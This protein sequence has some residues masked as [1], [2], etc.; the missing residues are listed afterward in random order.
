MTN[1]ITDIMPRSA[2][3]A[4]VLRSAV[5]RILVCFGILGPLSSVYGW[6]QVRDF[7]AQ[8][9]VLDNNATG[10]ITLQ[11]PTTITNNYSITLP[12]DTLGAHSGLL[13]FSNAGA[14]SLTTSFLAAGTNGQVLTLVGGTPTWSTSPNWLTVGNAGLTAS[15][16]LGTT[17]AVDLRFRANNLER[18]AINSGNFGGATFSRPVPAA[19]LSGSFNIVTSQ[20]FVDQNNTTISSGASMLYNQVQVNAGITGFATGDLY[21]SQNR[22]WTNGATGLAVG[23]VYGTYNLFSASTSTTGTV[24]SFH[25]LGYTINNNTAARVSTLYGI[26]T[27]GV[28]TNVQPPTQFGAYFAPFTGTSF[29]GVRVA[30]QTLEAGSIP[31]LTNFVGVQVDSVTGSGTRFAYLYN[32]VSANNAF[33]VGPLGFTGIGTLAP[34]AKFTVSDNAARTAAFTAGLVSN[35]ATS[36]TASIAKVGL[37]VQST[38]AWSGTGATNTGLSVNV[39]G[40][41]TNYAALF[42]GGNVGI[43]TTTPA[44]A[45]TV[46]GTAGTPNVRLVSVSGTPS[47]TA[48]VAN[49]GVVVADVNG[50]LTKRTAAAVIG[51]VAWLTTGNTGTTA[52]TNFLG[53]SDNQPFEIHVDAT[54][55]AT[56]G[57]RR[58]LRIEPNATSPNILFGFNG[59]SLGSAP[60][61]V[62]AVVSGG[63]VNGQP[64][65]AT[66]NFATVGGGANNRA[67]NL[68][69]D[70]SNGNYA[71]VSGGFTNIASGA[72]SFVGGGTSNNVSGAGAT[73]A[74]GSANV[75]AGQNAFVGGG[76]S[77]T[78][79][80]NLS[81]IT[82]GSA[83][84]NAGISSSILGGT[85][86]QIAA[87]GDY[88]SILGG[89]GLT[90]NTS[91]GSFGF[92]GNNPAGANNFSVT[93]NNTGFLGNV[94]LW[95]ANN[96]NTA[97][98]LRFY[99]PQATT[100][101][102]PDAATNYV[103]FQAGSAMANDNTYTLPTAVGTAGQV[104]RIATTPAPTA[105]TATLEW[106]ST[107]GT[108]PYEEA[109]AF[110]R[111]I[112]RITSLITGVAATPGFQ[113]TDL[114]GARA[115]ATQT[116][117]AN[118]S[119]IT[120]GSNNTVSGQ[121]AGIMSGSTNT[122]SANQGFIGGGSANTN[123]GQDAVIVGGNT[124]TLSTNESFIGAG[125][126]NSI[127]SGFRSVIG[128]GNAN[129]A[130][131]NYVSVTGGQSNVGSAQYA[132][133]T[134]GLSN[135]ASGNYATILGG[136]LNTAAG[137][138]NAV[139]GGRNLTVNANSV[140]GY[141]G[142]N[143]MTVTTANTVVFGSTNLW[144]ANNNSTA[145]ELRFY[146]PNGT[147]GAFPPAGINY[148]A[149]RAP[150]IAST[151]D[152]TYTLPAS[153]GTSGQYMRIA[154]SPAP[155]ATSATL[156]WGT[157]GISVQTVNV[158]ADN[159]VVTPNAATTF[160]RLDSD[161]APGARTITFAN[162]TVDGQQLVVRIVAT[163][164]N[165][166]EL[167]DAGTF[168]LSG[169]ATLRN[170]DTITLIWDNTS[171]LWIEVARRNN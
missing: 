86:N 47:G 89:R 67:G 164:T 125:N 21:L 80:G 134:G 37:D 108:S 84:T 96:D 43:G 65:R 150:T 5:L 115:L 76:S 50:D 112:R 149:F 93:A 36:S 51:G 165:G 159:Q 10:R 119:S 166:V 129:T 64:N 137:Q 104:L 144:L 170:T 131:A 59:N 148:V 145:S 122:V 62:G 75:V 168:V 19:S 117:S 9:L 20:M 141:N 68:D 48:L 61:A 139:W 15:N 29:T 136:E 44:L 57:R 142:G 79:S 60:T 39:S 87:G 98:Q 105:T 24:T 153:V 147:S 6:S 69:A 35:T 32:T 109:T 111:N 31:T 16:F 70:P 124:N 154:S 157:P 77:N 163:G 110:Q 143:A 103:A 161:G 88:T 49:D 45:F 97:R 4:S 171:T 2:F 152:Q 91:A 151:N 99:E 92:V 132:A 28:G 127:S 40:G 18:M 123:S 38:G 107:T 12:T 128:G 13:L 7:N 55:T 17:D 156:E 120:G 56:E 118:N 167:L 71:T 11:T 135:T 52:G 83:N 158:T 130:S 78:S 113:A 100:G 42:N 160:L 1:R 66:E 74:G 54:G 8:R 102:F 46:A 53:T 14:G 95:L 23:N 169:D 140:A 72:N 81:V 138:Y 26:R 114:Q 58:A 116:A 90:F 106:A 3:A 94:N 146:E 63:G 22:L 33:S 82:G 162:G 27:V 133:I 121:N 73:V 101:P 41:T 34:S 85:G 126:S 25:G 155:T 30:N